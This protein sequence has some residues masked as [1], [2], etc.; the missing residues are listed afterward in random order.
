MRMK[1]EMNHSKDGELLRRSG[2]K[3]FDP[4]SNGITI[5]SNNVE[6]KHLLE[7]SGGRFR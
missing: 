1:T 3:V 2:G 6:E 5:M 4:V 7:G